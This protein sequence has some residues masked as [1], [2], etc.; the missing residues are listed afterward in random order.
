MKKEIRL[1]LMLLLLVIV[2]PSISAVSIDLSKTTYSPSE[3]LQAEITGNFISLSLENILIYEGDTPRSQPVI[4]DLTKQGNIYYFYAVLPNQ[5]GNYSL[6]IEGAEYTES[7]QTKTDIIS[8]EFKIQTNQSALQIN[9]GFILTSE[10]FSIKIK[11]IGSNQEIT[12][13]FNGF[14]QSHSL[15]ED[16]Q[17][18][19]DFSIEQSEFGKN[20]VSIGGYNIPVFI[21]E[22]ITPPNQTNQ[23]VINQSTINNQSIINQTTDFENLNETELEEYIEDLGETESLSCYDIGRVCLV[24]QNCEGEK[25]GSLEGSCCIGEC[26]EEKEGGISTGVIIGIIL[27]VIVIGIIGFMYW[28]GKK[29]QRPKSTD[30]ILKQ[31]EKQFQERMKDKADEVT[32]NLRKH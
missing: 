8:K 21:I 9:P 27:L 11:A 15:I 19:I 24:N 5:Q 6:K 30:E 13:N 23:S 1:L 12:S 29:G 3:T 16:V 20:A 2:I 25:V 17:K 32:G 26:V 22:I 7:G 4:S 10:D 31:K 28:K 18:T 14:S